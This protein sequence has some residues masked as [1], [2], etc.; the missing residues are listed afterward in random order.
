M[1][2]H[3]HQ[4]ARRPKGAEAHDV[5][6]LR[7]LT[8]LIPRSYNADGNGVRK[9]IELSKLV[10]TVREIRQ[11]FA[12]YVVQRTAGWYR[13]PVSGKEYRDSHFRFDID[14]PVTRSVLDILRAWKAVLE[15]RFD[16]QAF[17]MKLSERA[18]W[19]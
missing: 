15:K 11:L 10:L 4:I 2:S 8:L 5:A 3:V 14:L 7:T 1:R 12:G 6:V 19:L 18:F 16:Q 9:N 13:D 17:Y